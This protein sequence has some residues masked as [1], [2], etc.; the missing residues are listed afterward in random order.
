MTAS[1]GR[2][3]PKRGP[4]AVPTASL[5]GT[6]LVGRGLS[7]QRRGLRG[8]GGL[9]GGPPH[10]LQLRLHVLPQRV[11]VPLALVLVHLSGH[12]RRSGLRGCPLPAQD[13]GL[14][15]S[16]SGGP[17]PVV[18]AAQTSREGINDQPKLCSEQRA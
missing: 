10:A 11:Q 12:G 18:S 15:M 8:L 16:P 2:T 13:S 6:H 4:R 3:V 1:K 17:G 9:W 7:G 5:A 14:Q